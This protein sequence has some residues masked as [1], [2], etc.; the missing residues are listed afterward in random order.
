VIASWPQTIAV[1]PNPAQSFGQNLRAF[2]AILGTR[3]DTHLHLKS[4]AR[5]IP[6]ASTSGR[7]G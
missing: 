6:G 2:L 1:S 4:T 3:P 7:G 5:V